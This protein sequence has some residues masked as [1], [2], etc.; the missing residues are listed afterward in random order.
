LFLIDEM[1]FI[2]LYNMKKFLDGYFT[3]HAFCLL[4]N[5]FH[6]LLTTNSIE[7]IYKHLSDKDKDTLLTLERR[8]IESNDD[9]RLE[10]SHS[11]LNLQFIRLFTSYSVRFNHKFQRSGN[12][13]HRPYKRKLVYN[14]E[15]FKKLVLYIHKNPLKHKLDEPFDHYYWSSYQEYIHQDE[16]ISAHEKTL[17]LFKSLKRFIKSHQRKVNYNKVRNLLLEN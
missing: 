11:V 3:V 12:L 15:Y 4:Q 6:V 8:F 9:Q 2:F 7:S 14:D 5:H 1:R 17:C 10:L 16:Y 13:F